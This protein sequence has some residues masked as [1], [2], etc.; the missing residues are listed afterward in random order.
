MCMIIGYLKAFWHDFDCGPTVMYY[1][2]GA[3][4]PTKRKRLACHRCD[5]TF[6]RI[7]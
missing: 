2:M 3:F 4:R 1:S 6:W 5:K 7:I